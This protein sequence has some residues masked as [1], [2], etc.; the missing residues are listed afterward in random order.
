MPFYRLKHLLDR[1]LPPYFGYRSLQEINNGF[2]TPYVEKSPKI[3]LVDMIFGILYG[4]CDYITPAWTMQIEFLSSFIIMTFA[5]IVVNFR[6]RWIIYLFTFLYFYIPSY[7]DYL[8]E[9]RYH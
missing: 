2:P 9:T 5:F 4:N 8:G 1:L 6:N 7:Y 3:Y